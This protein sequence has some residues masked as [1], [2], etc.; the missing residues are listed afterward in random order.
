MG[1]ANLLLEDVD[2]DVEQGELGLGALRGKHV[3]GK[4]QRVHHLAAHCGGQR[5]KKGDGG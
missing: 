2:E 5:D 1:V 3:H 4:R